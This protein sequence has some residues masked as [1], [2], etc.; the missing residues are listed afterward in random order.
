MAEQGPGGELNVSLMAF[1]LEARSSMTQ[2]LFFR[3]LASQVTL[4]HCSAK[5]AVDTVVLAGVRDA[6]P[7]PA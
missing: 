7:V 3:S 5:V 2:V 4:R 1:G 6:L